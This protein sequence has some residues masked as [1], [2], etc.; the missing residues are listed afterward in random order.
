MFCTWIDCKIYESFIGIMFTLAV[1][2]LRGSTFSGSGTGQSLM[3][4]GSSFFFFFFL[5]NKRDGGKR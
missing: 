1:G 2:S 3:V 4:L 5:V